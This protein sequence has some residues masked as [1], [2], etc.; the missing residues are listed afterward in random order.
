MCAMAIAIAGIVFPWDEIG[1]V[2]HV[3]P[4]VRVFSHA[5]VEQSYPD[6]FAVQTEIRIRRF[7]AYG[8]PTVVGRT[9]ER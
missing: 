6:A 2:P 7:G 3:R 1:R 5:A 4:Q 8:D 9:V